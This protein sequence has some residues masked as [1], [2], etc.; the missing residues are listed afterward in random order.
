MLSCTGACSAHQ[1]T[2]PACEMAMDE[3]AVAAGLDPIELRRR[4]EPEIDPET[5]L[6]FSD[7]RLIE[8]LEF[9]AERFGW[10]ERAGTPGSRLA[11]HS[12]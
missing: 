1:V 9:G 5:G 4:N 12:R 10:S 3:L 2:V 6:P 7:R 11:S 8:C